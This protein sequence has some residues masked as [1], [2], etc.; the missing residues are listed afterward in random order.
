VGAA[1]AEEADRPAA[2]RRTGRE[3]GRHRH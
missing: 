2:E 1:D 3:V